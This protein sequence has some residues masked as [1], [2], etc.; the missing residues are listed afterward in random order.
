MHSKKRVRTR[1]PEVQGPC[2]RGLERTRCKAAQSMHKLEKQSATRIVVSLTSPNVAKLN[3]VNSTYTLR[4][5][6]QLTKLR[7]GKR[8]K[9]EVPFAVNQEPSR[10]V[11]NAA[12]EER[13]AAA[14][15]RS[16]T[17][18]GYSIF[19]RAGV[20]GRFA[21]GAPRPIVSPPRQSARSPRPARSP[22]PRGRRR[23]PAR[24]SSPPRPAICRAEPFRA[25]RPYRAA[26]GR[27][28][29]RG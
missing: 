28:S 14:R 25:R 3:D 7:P 24:E 20:G 18:R 8:K 26:Y 15:R 17:A 1:G 9:A 23:R 6:N 13:P 10:F 29:R 21:D 16:L 11:I 19:A 27:R 12:S 2:P 4:E 22:P 5:I